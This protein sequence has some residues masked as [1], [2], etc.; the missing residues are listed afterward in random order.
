MNKFLSMAGSYVSTAALA[1]AVYPI[2]L[3]LWM[4][5]ALL[6]LKLSLENYL[7]FRF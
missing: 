1:V 3:C 5:Y 2:V 7:R 6:K 4:V